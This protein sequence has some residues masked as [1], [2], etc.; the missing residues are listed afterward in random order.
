MGKKSARFLRHITSSKPHSCPTRLTLLSA[1]FYRWGNWGTERL[2]CFRCLKT[3]QVCVEARIVVIVY[4]LSRV[5]LSCNP[6]DCSPPGFSVYGFSHT[7]ILEC[8]AISFSRGSSQPR[9]RTCGSCFG[10][11]ILYHWTTKE[12]QSQNIW[13]QM[14]ITNCSC[15][16]GLCGHSIT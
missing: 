16:S 14:V 4:S 8:V 7:R 15:L 6:M 9:D 10:R 12:A 11:W 5:W 3:T 1:Q 13:P 2:S